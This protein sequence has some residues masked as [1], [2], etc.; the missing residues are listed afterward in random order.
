MQ[1]GCFGSPFFRGQ[2]YNKTKRGDHLKS[3]TKELICAILIVLFI[4]CNRVRLGSGAWGK[5]VYDRHGI[6]LRM[7]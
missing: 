1:R 2:W 3:S 5:V 6:P 4:G 7:N